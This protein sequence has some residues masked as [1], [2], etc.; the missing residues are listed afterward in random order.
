MLQCSVCHS[1]QFCGQEAL[2]KQQHGFEACFRQPFYK[3]RN[4]LE[5]G[6]R[7]IVVLFKM[8]LYDKIIL[9]LI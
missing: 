7:N 5:W 6:W 8:K 4:E 9:F 3:K 2:V 1:A